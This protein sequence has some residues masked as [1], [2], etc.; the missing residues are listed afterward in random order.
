MTSVTGFDFTLDASA[1]DVNQMKLILHEWAKKWTFQKESGSE[2]SYEHYQCRMHLHVKQR[3][4]EIIAKTAHLWPGKSRRWSVTSKTVHEGQ[5][6]NYVMKADT[7]IEG[8]WTDKDYEEPPKLT[9]QL[10]IFNTLEFHPWQAQ[11]KQWCLEEDDRSIKLIYDRHGDAGKSIMA[12]YLEYHGMAYEIPPFRQMEDIMQVVMSIKDKKAYLIDM[13]RAMKK[14]K[15]GEF[16]SGL[17][18]LKNGIAYDKRYSFKKKRMDRPQ[19]IVFTNTLPQFDMLSLDRWQ[20][21]ELC[22]DKTLNA[23]DVHALLCSPSCS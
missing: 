15:L 12:E 14:D 19:V 11:V 18:A 1:C 6:F 3:E 8:P 5:N 2:T 23:I 17:E 13:P 4:S 22:Q 9:R 21:W 10:R 20:V 16:Y 7:R